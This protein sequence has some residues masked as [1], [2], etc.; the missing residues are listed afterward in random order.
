MWQMDEDLEDARDEAAREWAY[1]QDKMLMAEYPNRFLEYDEEADDYFEIEDRRIID[2]ILADIREDLAEDVDPH[3][4][5][6]KKP[7]SK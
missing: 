7:L 3:N 6:Y 1:E 2:E 5:Y 4:E